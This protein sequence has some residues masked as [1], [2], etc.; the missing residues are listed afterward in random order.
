MTPFKS[1]YQT[2]ARGLQKRRDARVERTHW[3]QWFLLLGE[4]ERSH[5]SAPDPAGLKPLY[6]PADRFW[7]DPFAWSEGGRRFIY[8]EEYPLHTAR[9]RISALEIGADLEPLGPAVPVIDE[10]RH[11]SYPF[12]FRFAGNL[13]LVPESAASRRVDLYR[14]DRFPFGWTRVGT[15]LADIQAADATLFEHQGRWWLFCSARQ[16]KARLNNALFAFHADSPIS[17]RWTAHPGNPLVLDYAGARPGGRVFVDDQGR[18][19][20][21]VQ[22]SVPRYG[23]G[24]GLNEVLELTPERFRERPVWHATG[25]AAGGWR[26]LHHLDWHQG[27]MVMDAQRLIPRP[28]PGTPTKQAEDTERAPRPS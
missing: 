20:R 9:G 5:W 28:A 8:L 13:Y 15:L 19:L 10:E 4:R 11:L 22:H 17:D 24:L 16:G 21:P 2:L 27:L 6:P 3:P 18:L 1:I 25:A 12:L 7:A 26:A 14:C 23:Y